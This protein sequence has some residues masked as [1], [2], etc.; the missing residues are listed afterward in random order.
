M[1]LHLN[2]TDCLDCCWL[3]ELFKEKLVITEDKGEIIELLTII[4]CH[5]SISKVA[6]IFNISEYTT[7]QIREL[8][9]QK[10]SFQC[11]NK[12]KGLASL[13]R[14]NKLFLYFMGVNQLS[15][16]NEERLLVF[17]FQIKQRWRNKNNFFYLTFQRFMHSSKEKTLTG[18]LAF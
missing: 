2:K 18:K 16:P 12:N 7:R 1:N 3:V 13:K 10:E 17:D 15:T 8:R 6:E 9:L 11:Q 4:R 5:L 14:P